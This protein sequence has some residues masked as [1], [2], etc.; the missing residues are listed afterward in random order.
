MDNT[1]VASAKTFFS[2]QEKDTIVKAIQEA[3]KNT[4]GEIRL[5]LENK[6]S[7]DPMHRAKEVFAELKMHKTEL[8]NGVLIYIAVQ[9]HQVAIW[10]DEGINYHVGQAFWDDEVNIITTH[11]KAG[12]YTEGVSK[13]IIQVGEN[14]KK[15]F[16]FIGGDTNELSDE[17][18]IN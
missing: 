10:G 8:K 2:E 18:S 6:C 13:A 4:S 3:E 15:Y 16:P 5:H 14:L 17:I 12:K 1:A 11:F 9:D 7:R